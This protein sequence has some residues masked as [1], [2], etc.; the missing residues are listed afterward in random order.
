MHVDTN[1][2]LLFQKQ[3]KSVDDEWPKVRIVWVTK[4]KTRIL[5]CNP[6]ALSPSFLYECAPWPLTYSRFHS[7]PFWF[8]GDI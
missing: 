4:N 8:W 7:D 5:R 1:S 3:S 2:H 6:W